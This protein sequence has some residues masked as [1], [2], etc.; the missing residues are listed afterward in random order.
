[1]CPIQ[2][3]EDKFAEEA[4][5][6]KLL[7]KTVIGVDDLTQ[8][9]NIDKQREHRLKRIGYDTLYEIA[10]ATIH[11]LAEDAHITYDA[12]QTMIKTAKLLLKHITI[13]ENLPPHL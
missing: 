2:D 1:M 10:E 3:D 8:L 4:H 13:W 11:E 12:A 5:P 7:V 9:P 6:N